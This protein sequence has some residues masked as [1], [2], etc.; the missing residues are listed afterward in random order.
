MSGST[1]RLEK[2]ESVR[3]LAA[4]YVFIH[5]YVHCNPQLAHLQRFFIF[6]QTAV[7]VFFILSGFVIYYSSVGKDAD[8][9]VRDYLVRRVRRIY[10][11][12]I[13]VMLL[14]WVIGC[15]AYREWNDFDLKNFVGNV[16]MLQDKWHPY[17][18]FAPYGGNSPLW[19][20]SYEWWF[21]LFF[22]PTYFLFKGHAKRQQFF[23]ITISLAGFGT[24]MLAPNQLSIM[25]SYFVMWWSGVELAREYM[26]IGRVSWRQQLT[27][28]VALTLMTVLWTVVAYT[29][30]KE[31]AVFDR[32]IYPFVQMQHFFTVLLMVVGSIA[33]FKLRF[34]LFAQTIGVFKVLSPVSY[35][36]YIIHL[37]LILFAERIRVTGSVWLDIIW[38][39]PLIFG[40]AWL[41]EVPLQRW[42]NRVVK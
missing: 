6:G 12:Y 5:H 40:L 29:Q 17:A 14:G 32:G 20:L 10:P 42:I 31:T 3:G 2:L 13:L 24:F 18:W 4:F 25:A 41:I 11:A 33:W 27:S 1:P 16:L 34:V 36:L 22:V 21:Y 39:F 9:S 26:A 23:A 8:F 28:I 15:I 30:W 35:V 19:S 38:L 7:M 37:P